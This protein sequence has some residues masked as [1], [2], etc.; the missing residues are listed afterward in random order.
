MDAIVSAL[1]ERLKA[2]DFK[3]VT[4]ESCTGGLLTACLT[5]VA[6]SSAYVDRGFVTYSNDSK[7]EM[8]GVPAALIDEHG[9]V[10][11]EVAE[12]MAQGALKVSAA[13]IAVSITGIAG[14]GGGSETKPVGLVYIGMATWEAAKNFQYNF[15]GSREDVRRQSVEAALA[16]LI[17]ALA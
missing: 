13:Q 17:K 15:E 5:N 12:A 16:L 11:G 3:I 4:V 8:V 6:G 9:A 2:H 7:I 10:S 1:F 14:P